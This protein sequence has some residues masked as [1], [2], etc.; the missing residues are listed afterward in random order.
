[1]V[2]L[3]KL[4]LLAEDQND[5]DDEE[6]ELDTQAAAHG[7]FV[8]GL[9]NFRLFA[10]STEVAACRRERSE[11]ADSICNCTQDNDCNFIERLLFLLKFGGLDNAVT[12]VIQLTIEAPRNSC[13]RPEAILNVLFNALSHVHWEVWQIF[14]S[15]KNFALILDVVLR[16]FKAQIGVPRV[17]FLGELFNF[18]AVFDF[19]IKFKRVEDSVGSLGYI[20][21]V[22]AWLGLHI[23]WGQR[24]VVSLSRTSQ[25]IV[26]LVG[27][28]LCCIV[29][30]RIFLYGVIDRFDELYERDRA[31]GGLFIWS[32][33]NRILIS[34]ISRAS[35]EVRRACICVSAVWLPAEF[36][37]LRSQKGFASPGSTETHVIELILWFGGLHRNGSARFLVSRWTFWLVFAAWATPDV[38]V[39]LR[40]SHHYLRSGVGEKL[41]EFVD[42]ATLFSAAPFP[43]KHAL[44]AAFAL[45]VGDAHAH[46]R[47]CL[48]VIRNGRDCRGVLV[49]NFANANHVNG[50]HDTQDDYECLSEAA[51]PQAF[52]HVFHS[53]WHLIVTVIFIW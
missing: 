27:D 28:L 42:E 23:E 14:Q 45:I 24:K 47:N 5:S 50:D 52:G 16:D 17:I 35:Y 18:S 43:H 38:V 31:F 26:I 9:A 44:L 11:E 46:K 32:H 8:C 49:A 34:G 51:K 19:A 2:S 41:I 4:L 30:R 15:V 48:P 21:V 25:E 13:T 12:W 37:S 7:S 20:V 6:N 39:I 29:S 22:Q 33:A 36:G 3:Q 10:L 53:A 1:M 40:L